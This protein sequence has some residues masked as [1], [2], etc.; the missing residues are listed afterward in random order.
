MTQQ[1]PPLFNLFMVMREEAGLPL[2]I[3][4]YD[5]L[6]TALKGGFGV[7]SREDLKQICRLL[8]VKSKSLLQE[9]QFEQCF[10]GYFQKYDRES[11]VV[12]EKP[13]PTSKD[14]VKR[15]EP[16]D[17]VEPEKTEP[18]NTPDTTVKPPPQVPIALKG[19]LL[20]KNQNNLYKLI[21]NDF[22]VTKRQI[23]QGWRYFRRPLREGALTEIDIAATIQKVCQEGIFLEP[24]MIPQRINRAEILL[25]ID[26]SNSMIPFNLLSQ[27]LLDNLQG[28][29]L[30]KAEVY[31]FLNCPGNHL[32]LHP[33]SSQVKSIE[34]L[35][36]K[37]HSKRTV[38]LIVSDGGAA[39]GGVSPSRIEFT[40]EFI[41]KFARCVRHIAWLNPI[42][43][44][45]WEYTTAEDILQ[46]VQMFELNSSGFKAAIRSG[47]G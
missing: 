9:K 16:T 22:P 47:K 42:P 23:Q 46:F 35:L 40:E 21:P 10:D 17:T 38:V 20:P 28:G 33:Q 2:T 15:E 30:G 8:W 31:Y 36:P 3:D 24:V 39:R 32:Y 11:K 19:K 29:R 37:L 34:D 4:Q 12:K 45:R 41:Q 27:R 44:E 6:L 43:E 14:N 7:A 1:T 26:V 5:L 18:P 25:L 13:A